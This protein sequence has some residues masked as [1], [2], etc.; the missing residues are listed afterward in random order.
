MGEPEKGSMLKQTLKNLCCSNGWCYGVFWRFDQRNS[1]L[2]T[3]EDAYY[4]EQMRP[5]VNSM[6]QKFHILGE[7]IIG[8][9]AFTGKHRWIFSDS[10]GKSSNS[11]TGNQITFQDESELQNQISCGIK[12]IAIISLGR[13][14]AVQVGSTQKI[15]ERL[16]F[17][18][19]T[20]KLF[21]DVGSFHGLT[22][23]EIEACNQDDSFAA[24]RSCG[25]IYNENLATE[26]YGFP[27]E[28]KGWPCSLKNVTESSIFMREIRDPSVNSVVQNLSHLRNQRQTSNAEALFLSSG[29]ISPVNCLAAYTP[30]TS[31]WRSEGSILTSFETSFPSE[32]GIWDSPNMLP[33]ANDLALSGNME[34]KLQGASTFSSLY[35][36]GELV[37]A[38]LPTLDSY[39][40][41]AEYQCSFGTN[42][43]LLD[44]AINLQ[45][46]TEEFNPAD[47]TIDLCNSFN[48]DD[49]SQLFSPLPQHDINGTGATIISDVSSSVGVTSV[50]SALVGGDTLVDIP[51]QQTANSLQS[52]ITEAS[53]SNAEISTIVHDNGTDLFDGVGLDYAFGKTGESLE[54]IIVPLLHGDNATVTSGMSETVSQLDVRAMNGKRK[55]L[56][57]ELGLEKLLDGVNNSSHATKSSVEDQLSIMKRRKT[58]S[59]SSSFCQGQF[60][61]LSYSGG[62]MNPVHHSHTIFNKDIHRKSQVGAW[63]DYSY[64]VNGGQA[65]AATSKKPGKKRAKPGESTRPRPKDRQLIQDRIKE[66]RGIIPHNGKPLSIDHLLEQT[67]KYLI[68][69]QG[70]TKYADKIKQADEPKIIG[71]E[72]GMLPKHNMISGGA[73]WAFEVGAQSIPI[74]VKDLNPPGQ[75]LIEMLCEDQGFFLEI[76]NVIRGIGLNILRAVMELQEDKIWAR[77]IVEAKEQVERTCII[78]SLLPLLQQ[79]GGSGID[80]ASQPSNDVN[81][82]IPLSNNY[83]QPFPL[84]P[85][86]MAETFQ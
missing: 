40:K 81:G 78:W 61:G 43:R 22:P 19:E 52:S 26:L 15:L 80:S 33:K 27:R 31:T 74:V 70:V 45:R 66:L 60:V 7:G 68:F 86:N 85:L 8:Q 5:L 4:E 16:D 29:K 38:E 21:C 18:D 82:G 44:D 32:S 62:S 69:L 9:A 14:G 37:D 23:L 24:L 50:S 72:D 2:L 48:L 73:T 36:I 55:G 51:V 20:K 25:N 71:N 57:S 77:F 30:C 12:T 47:F 64:S 3:M 65:V 63:I 35:S 58:E 53:I 6:L 56:F 79:T 13:Q 67:I 11:Y 83:L 59:S 39:G 76:A 54:D 17:L 34:Q 1:M 41:T 46:I 10:Y 49:L 42:S 28:P 84:P 75:M